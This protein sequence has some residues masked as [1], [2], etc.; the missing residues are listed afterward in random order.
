MRSCDTTSHSVAATSRP[1]YSCNDC[2]DVSA[3]LAMN[4]AAESCSARLQAGER[5]TGSAL[6][7]W[8]QFRVHLPD[9]TI[10]HFVPIRRG[11]QN[12]CVKR[13]RR[14]RGHDIVGRLPLLHEHGNLIP[15]PKD[16]IPVRC[17]GG[18]VN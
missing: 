3:S 13:S 17:D 1:T 12:I 2:K 6:R 4:A 14:M 5:Y 10:R 16:H 18:P 8:F 15:N 7:S 11:R 9:E